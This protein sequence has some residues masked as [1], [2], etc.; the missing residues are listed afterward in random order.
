[1]LRAEEAALSVSQHTRHGMARSSKPRVI[2]KK[3]EEK[4]L[5]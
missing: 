1:M 5:T 3:V 2:K 4:V